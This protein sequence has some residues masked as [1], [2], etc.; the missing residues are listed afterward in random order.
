MVIKGSS[1][2]I[3]LFLSSFLIWLIWSNKGELLDSVKRL[4]VFS[5]V[6]VTELCLLKL[7]QVLDLFIVTLL[8]HCEHD[9]RIDLTIVQLVPVD[10]L[11]EGVSSDLI[12][13]IYTNALL[14]VL[15]K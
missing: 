2:I 14:R 5:V 7:L 8:F 15:V 10:G 1:C 13:V 12:F 6:S 4:I 3:F 11:E 9:R